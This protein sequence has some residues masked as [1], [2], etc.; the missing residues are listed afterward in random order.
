MDDETKPMDEDEMMDLFGDNT[1]IPEVIVEDTETPVELE[2]ITLDETTDSQ[3]EEMEE[4]EGEGTIILHPDNMQELANFIGEDEITEL[5][6]DL[7]DAAYDQQEKYLAKFSVVKEIDTFLG[8]DWKLSPLATVDETPD[9]IKFLRSIVGDDTADLIQKV[10]DIQGIDLEDFVRIRALPSNLNRIDIL[11]DSVG[12]A[13]YLQLFDDQGTDISD[14]IGLP[15]DAVGQLSV[16]TVFSGSAMTALNNGDRKYSPATM[17]KSVSTSFQN[18]YD[19][20]S[21]RDRRKERIE[22]LQWIRS[23]V[24]RLNGVFGFDDYRQLEA[25]IAAWLMKNSTCR[26]SGI[27][28][29]GKTT[30]INCAATLLGNSYGY[31]INKTYL[32]SDDTMDYYPLD[33]NNTHQYSTIDQIFAGNENLT[34]AHVADVVPSGQS[35]NVMYNDQRND[36]IYRNWNGWRFR[37]WTMD[38]PG[39]VSLSG[40]YT[41]GFNFLRTTEKSST[42]DMSKAPIP[43]FR[44][45]LPAIDGDT[46]SKK[47]I[48]PQKFHKLLF[49]CWEVEVPDDFDLAASE[50]GTTK[51][52]WIPD[53]EKFLEKKK[54]GKTRM[55][56]KP[57]QIHDGKKLT[58]FTNTKPP[59]YGSFPMTLRYPDYNSDSYKAAFDHIDVLKNGKTTTNH[60]NDYVNSIGQ[61][62]LY[63]DT[64]RNEGF[65]MRHLMCHWFYDV[66]IKDP[67]AGQFDISVEMLNEIGVAK[68]DYDKRPD[69]VLYGLE[70]RAVEAV[71]QNGETVNTYEFE[72]VPREIVTQPIKF[73]NEANRSQSGVEDAILGLIAE[74][75]VEYRGKIFKSPDFVAWMDTNPHQ[76]GNDLAFTDR[77]DMELLFKSV[78]LGGRYD[79]LVNKF[80]GKGGLEPNRILV[81]YMMSDSNDPNAFKPMRI[82]NLFDVWSMVGKQ[83]FTSPGSSYDGFREISVI[84]VLFSQIFASR[85]RNVNI[86]GS[87]EGVDYSFSNVDDNISLDLYESPLLDYSTTTNTNTSDRGTTSPVLNDDTMIFGSSDVAGQLPTVFTRVLGF[88]FTNSLVKLSQA[89]A[90]LRGKESVSR[91]EILDAVPYVIAHRMGRAKSGAK[92]MEGNNK[93]LDGNRIGYVN[94]QEFIREMVVKGYIEGKIEGVAMDEKNIMDNSDYFYNHCRSIMD[95]VPAVWEYEELVLRPLYTAISEKEVNSLT[96]IHWHIATMVVEEERKGRGRKVARNYSASKAGPQGYAS[97]QKAPTNYH[98]MYSNY[99][100]LILSPSPN[101]EPCLFDYYRLRGFIAREINLFTNDRERLLRMLAGEVRSIAGSDGLEL[102]LEMGSTTVRPFPQGITPLGADGTTLTQ[103]TYRPIGMGPWPRP[104]QTYW[105]TYDDAQGAYGSLI[106]LGQ[107]ATYDLSND[108]S[109]LEIDQGYTV[110]AANQS[111]RVTGRYR[112]TANLNQSISKYDISRTLT[113]FAKNF[114]TSVGSGVNLGDDFPNTKGA[115]PSTF[116]EWIKSA[117]RFLISKISDPTRDNVNDMWGCFELNH[118][119]VVTPQMGL[120]GVK[121]NDKLRLWLRLSNIGQSASVNGGDLIDMLFT[122]G[123]TSAPALTSKANVGLEALGQDFEILSVTDAKQYVSKQWTLGNKQLG[124]KTNTAL[125]DSGNMLSLDRLYYNNMF[126]KSLE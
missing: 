118:A 85:P 13:H 88:R 36:T 65:W 22:T 56:V 82:G 67:K 103:T 26:L 8:P 3:I 108:K 41:Y 47:S 76:R 12:T 124:Y 107:V 52:H 112:Q 106:G 48:D 96:P 58:T 38:Q 64:G 32:A 40:S 116:D 104:E 16:E 1:D 42:V 60:L 21:D 126:A 14:S 61:N 35:Y 28:G 4:D 89:F 72:P 91:Q 113:Q 92:D 49:N 117:Q 10:A 29:T 50:A 17:G 54:A 27:P 83:K 98:E 37:D 30:V 44:C 53:S 51:T 2:E 63:T 87:D 101:G 57:I 99:E 62:G 9:N 109:P 73:F 86:G 81:D 34:N 90:F 71:N 100:D 39:T 69:E 46:N 94:E 19:I 59:Q 45:V 75:M 7:D 78:S 15:L 95:S 115:T 5:I 102:D 66:R 33:Y 23:L 119:P 79:Q 55:V 111:L 43:D 74:K 24:T 18:F 31:H 110:A 6:P 77:I 120:R 123:I 68:I 114:R 93:G 84:S 70:I 20:M 80:T 11:D 25:F 125:V 97:I 105:H 121:G 122:V